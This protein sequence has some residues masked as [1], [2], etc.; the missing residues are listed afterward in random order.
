MQAQYQN[1]KEFSATY[2]Y[3]MG[4]KG[5]RIVSFTRKSFWLSKNSDDIKLVIGSFSNM[6][7]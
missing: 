1:C 5:G 6:L 7:L 2:K 3:N 4:I